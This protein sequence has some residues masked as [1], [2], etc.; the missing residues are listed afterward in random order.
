MTQGATELDISDSDL[1]LCLV[2]RHL[3]GMHHDREHRCSC[4]P[5]DEAW[6][7][8]NWAGY[9]IA[10]AI[11]LCCLCA[12]GVMKSGSRWS[13]LVCASCLDVNRA[14]GSALGSDRYGALPVGRHSIMNGVAMSATSVDSE[15]DSFV[16]RLSALGSVRRDLLAWRDDEVTRL[17]QD[18]GLDTDAVE[19]GEWMRLHPVSVGASADA[20]CRFVGDELPDLPELADL[21]AARDVFLA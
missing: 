11:D 13:W 20:F 3:R 15:L 14:V 16:A 5:Q 18:A 17:A 4:T 21:R 12:R 9:D 19:L 6:L 7:E 1:T 2:C 10:A 8:S